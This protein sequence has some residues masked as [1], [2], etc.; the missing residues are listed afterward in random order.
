MTLMAH[1]IMAAV[2]FAIIFPIGGIIIRLANFTGL[3]WVHAAIQAIG[4]LVFTAA[5]GLGIYVAR[6]LDLLSNHHPIIGIVVFSILVFQP[7]LGLLHHMAFKKTGKRGVWSFAHIGIGR[8]A[9]ILGII[10]GGLGLQL[11]GNASTHWFIA[12][13]VVGGVFGLAYIAS[14][15]FGEVKMAKKKKG[16]LGVGKNSDRDVSMESENPRE[17]K[18]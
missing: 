3:T 2:A 11:A 10:N 15:V 17:D 5:F 16:E 8:V 12:Y 13:S 4:F 1:G 14:A 9:I 6:N 7:I 18:V